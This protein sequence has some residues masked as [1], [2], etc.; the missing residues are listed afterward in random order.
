MKPYLKVASHKI[1]CH[2]Y[3]TSV[4]TILISCF[5]YMHIPLMSAFPRLK[6]GLDASSLGALDA[7]YFHLFADTGL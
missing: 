1:L 7:S 6:E 5:L 4:A 3:H 2:F